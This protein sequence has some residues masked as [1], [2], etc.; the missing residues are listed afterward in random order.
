MENGRLLKFERDEETLLTLAER[1]ADDGDYVGSLG[2]LFSIYQTKPDYRVI[3]EIADVYADMGLYEYS[4]RFWYK[5]L[6]V[7]PKNKASVAYEELGINYFYLDNL[8]AAGY[9]FQAKVAEDGFISREGL[10][11]EIIDFLSESFPPKPEIKIVY[12]EGRADYTEDIKRAKST[13]VSGNYPLAYKLYKAIPLSKMDENVCGDAQTAFF[14]AEKDDEAIEAC[15]YSLFAHGENVTAYCNLSTV[16][17]MKDDEEKSAYYYA[18][19]LD[20]K[21]GDPEEYYKIATCAVEQGDDANA[22]ECFEFII[23]ERPY[24]VNILFFYGLSLIN[25]GD[26][27]KAEKTLSKA[28]RI[29]PDDPPVGYY[30]SLAEKLKRGE[31]NA[32][33][34]LPLKYSRE[35]P[36][37]V[38]RDYK[39]KLKE[40]TEDPER[41]KS[42]F[43]KKENRNAIRYMIYSPDGQL[44]K[45]AVYVLTISFSKFAE[46]TVLEALMSPEMQPELKRYMIYTLILNGR[47]E[48]FGAVGGNI[49]E[50][51]KPG[52]LTFEKKTDGIIF[53]AAYAHAVSRLAFIGL[54]NP[55]KMAFYA[56]AVY[57]KLGGVVIDNPFLPEELGA[58]IALKC[59]YK[60]VSEINVLTRIFG[61]KKERLLEIQAAFDGEE[62]IKDDKNN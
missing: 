46:K 43:K 61:V 5:Y 16:Y 36:Q 7:A 4:N 41:I 35:L 38:S 30:L 42:F 27:E 56:N 19:A 55:E 40:L 45:L 54:K 33:K 8:W 6:D 48:S 9:Y 60:G 44:S 15:K 31:K 28:L 3:S 21:K 24:D 39:K 1:R 18:R 2:F 53:V 14:L 22:K 20:C 12:P 26:Y 58:F 57:K 52:K 34:L 17:K 59:G 47:K 23:T 32:E 13:L 37:K 11:E 10:D 62:E 49:Y 51:I 50:K 29:V 25:L